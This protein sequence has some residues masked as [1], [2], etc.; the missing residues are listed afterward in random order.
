VAKPPTRTE[1]ALQAVAKP[2]TRT[3]HA[4][5][6]AVIRHLVEH[7]RKDIYFFAIPNA[8]RRGFQT[9][10]RMK[11]EGLRAGVV[12]LCIMASWG[13]TY[14][15]ELKRTPKS[16]RS[17]AQKGFAAICQR[18]DHAHAWAGSFDEA[19][20]ILTGWALLK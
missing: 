7:G 15:M 3:E 8:G 5:Q 20:A 14:W 9:A 19:I 13:R 1:H 10:A 12:D 6:A 4:L 11:A 18:L 17:D 16:T 2:P